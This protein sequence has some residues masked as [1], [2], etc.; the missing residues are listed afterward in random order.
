MAQIGI[1]QRIAEGTA[2]PV[3][4]GESERPVGQ[5]VEQLQI[6]GFDVRTAEDV[7]DTYCSQVLEAWDTLT[8]TLPQSAK[9]EEF[10]F[11]VIDEGEKWMRRLAAL[12][13][14]DL[15]VYRFYAMLPG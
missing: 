15:R 4:V 10:K 13:T 7:T 6:N 12:N 1:D 8:T 9:T 11:V 14:G 2:R 3:A 5:I